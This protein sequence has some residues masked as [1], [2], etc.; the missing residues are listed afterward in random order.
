MSASPN[1]AE[2]QSSA[3]RRS[4]RLQ[5]EDDRGLYVLVINLKEAC[6]IKAGRL[7]KTALAPGYYLYVGRARRH[8]SGRLKR[9]MQQE[10][11]AF[12]HIDYLLSYS[13]IQEI[14]IK[15]GLLDECLTA[16]KILSCSRKASFPIPGFG[17][18]D[19]RC[20]SHLLRVSKEDRSWRK[21]MKAMNF[22]KAV[23]HGYP[24]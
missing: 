8:L 2:S 9:H 18:S 6:E 11:N 4:V 5:T 21:L 7:P 24:A 12:W 1:T 17:S 15:N 16:G 14:W 19:C 13:Q 22:K 10:K 3:H 20:P 23:N